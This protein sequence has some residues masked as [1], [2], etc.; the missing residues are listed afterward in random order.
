[1]L[2]LVVCYKLIEVSELL[3]ASFFR[4]MIIVPD[5]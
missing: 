3:D 1:M 4:A 2:R 5:F